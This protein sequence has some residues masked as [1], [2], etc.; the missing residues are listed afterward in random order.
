MNFTN[1]NGVKCLQVP[2]VFSFV[3]FFNS[4]ECVDFFGTFVKIIQLFPNI[5][6]FHL[7]LKAFLNLI[8]KDFIF[9]LDTER[10]QAKAGEHQ[11]EGEGEADSLLSREPYMEL[12]SRT[13]E[14]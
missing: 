8:F 10:E 7:V 3:F 12:D 6:N 13:P 11:E 9:L 4:F 2:V 5:H 14:S 1:I